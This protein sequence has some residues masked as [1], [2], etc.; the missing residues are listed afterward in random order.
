MVNEIVSLAI[1]SVPKIKFSQY[2]SDQD[3]LL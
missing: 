2:S 1:I 3:L